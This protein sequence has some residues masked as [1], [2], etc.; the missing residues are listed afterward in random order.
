[1]QKIESIIGYI[2]SEIELIRSK[3]KHSDNERHIFWYEGVLYCL[4]DLKRKILFE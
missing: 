4:E 1:M 2:E 3:I